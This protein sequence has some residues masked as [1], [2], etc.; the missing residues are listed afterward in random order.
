[1]YSRSLWV[2]G[3]VPN[4]APDEQSGE[5][6]S[7][8]LKRG[9]MDRRMIQS[10]LPSGLGVASRSNLPCVCWGLA[11]RCRRCKPCLP[12]TSRGAAR[13]GCL[14]V[15]GGLGEIGL[16]SCS[17]VPMPTSAPSEG[18]RGPFGVTPLACRPLVA[19]DLQAGRKCQM[20]APEP[21]HL[22]SLITKEVGRRSFDRR[23]T[24]SAS[25]WW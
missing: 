20:I 14:L 25:S 8:D 17:K 18:L 6:A 1:M 22:E 3:A 12:R 23:P 21:V 24:R 2:G 13:R 16:P 9:A 11:R 7:P 19:L 4:T 5:P 10:L 15:D